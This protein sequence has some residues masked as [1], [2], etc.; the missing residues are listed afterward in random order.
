MNPSFDLEQVVADWLRKEASASGSDRVLDAALGRV[1]T[2][3]QERRRPTWLHMPM[4]PTLKV[5]MLVATAVVIAVANFGHLTGSRDT[6]PGMVGSTPAPSSTP[7]PAVYPPAGEIPPGDRQSLT[8]DGVPLSF[9]VP[10]GGWSAGIQRKASA[11][12]FMAG[13][14]YIAKGT[15]GGQRAEAVVFWTAFP[16]GVNTG[17]CHNL[18]TQPIAADLAAVMATAPGTDLV[19]GPSEVTLGGHE[20]KHVVVTVREDRG[21]DPGYFFTWPDEC[22]G[23]CWIMTQVG[24]TIGVW[25]VDVDGRR[26]VIE[27]ETTRQGVWVVDQDGTRHFVEETTELSDAELE[28]E[29]QQIVQSIRFE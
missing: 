9:S 18:L 17:P 13:S 14:L 4:S 25:V 22:W 7:S 12:T 16:G 10:S 5:A 21:C 6:G 28:L 19:T 1:S 15:A 20:A 29:V 3:R 24:D 27:T 23:T 26:L 11:G 8:V 2:V